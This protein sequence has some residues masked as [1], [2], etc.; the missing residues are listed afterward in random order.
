MSVRRPA[1]ASSA[2]LSSFMRAVE[3][4]L[5]RPNTDYIDLY[6]MHRADY[7]TPVDE[8]LAARRDGLHKPWRVRSRGS[9]SDCFLSVGAI[10]KCI[11]GGGTGSER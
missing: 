4:S 7:A 5:R 2:C 1:S 6:Q 11:H 9:L 8:T 3:E 10:R